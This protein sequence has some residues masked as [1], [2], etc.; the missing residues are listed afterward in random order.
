MG[1][2]ESREC[3]FDCLLGKRFKIVQFST[4][5]MKKWNIWVF[6][7]FILYHMLISIS[8]K[9][10]LRSYS[11]CLWN[12]SDYARS[13]FYRKR[14]AII[15][16]KSPSSLVENLSRI[17]TCLNLWAEINMC[18]F[19]HCRFF[20]RSVESPRYPESGLVWIH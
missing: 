15:E 14:I 8:E 19:R 7:S 13:C 18:M 5:F 20:T 3:G 11:S 17:W 6:R 9:T 4:D 12:F 10:D 2:I 1:R 16:F